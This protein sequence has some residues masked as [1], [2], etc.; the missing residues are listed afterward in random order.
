MSYGGQVAEPRHRAALRADPLARNDELPFSDATNWHD[1]QITKTCP[2]LSQKIFR[3]RR[4]A[5]QWFLS[6]RL[7]R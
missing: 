3:F 6:A 2:A 1:G 7:T 4:R 5:N